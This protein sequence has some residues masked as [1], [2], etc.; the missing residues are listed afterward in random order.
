[1][2]NSEQLAQPSK[3]ATAVKLLYV[4][5][6]IGIIRSIIEFSRQAEESSVG[7]VLFIMLF[8]FGIM[9]FFIYMIGKGKNWARIAFLV[10]FIIGVPLSI[11]YMIQSLSHNPISGVL[12]LL[13]V[14][15]QVIGLVLLFQS[16]S[17]TWFKANEKNINL[18]LKIVLILSFLYTGIVSFLLSSG[19]IYFALSENGYRSS[20]WA[21]YA[22][23]NAIVN[24]VVALIIGYALYYLIAFKGVYSKASHYG[25]GWM[26]WVIFL[27]TLQILPKTMSEYLTVRADFN[28][29]EFII[30]NI[31]LN[32]VI[33]IFF[34]GYL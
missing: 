15:M 26:S 24:I 16:G 30:L 27:F 9:L 20:E 28:S 34:R 3:V 22:Y 12:G 7:F 25:R 4:T 33:E 11:S 2:I 29:S 13:Q 5:L 17:S 23:T 18:G 32:S 10:L 21:V 8:V 6:G 14:V 31:D 19:I 1:M